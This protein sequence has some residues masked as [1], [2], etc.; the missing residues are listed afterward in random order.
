MLD[1]NTGSGGLPSVHGDG[2][3][4]VMPT[5]LEPLVASQNANAEL[6]GQL[7]PVVALHGFSG[8][9]THPEQPQLPSSQV[10]APCCRS[11]HELIGRLTLTHLS[12]YVHTPKQ[13]ALSYCRLQCERSV[14][15]NNH[16]WLWG[17]LGEAS[18]MRAPSG[19]YV[20][21]NHGSIAYHHASCCR[22]AETDTY[23]K[24]LGCLVA[25]LILYESGSIV[26]RS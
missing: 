9:M 23:N 10:C 24:V 18:C 4:L 25:N 26:L 6:D 5:A 14:G 8:D 1:Q 7:S 12:A 19:L 2:L 17:R 20:G 22:L 21:C 13:C 15:T 3:S 11:M 16:R